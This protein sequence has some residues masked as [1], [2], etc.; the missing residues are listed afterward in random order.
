MTHESKQDKKQTLITNKMILQNCQQLK[1]S[2]SPSMS[3][4]IWTAYCT[5]QK[6]LIQDYCGVIS[7]HKSSSSS[8]NAKN[9]HVR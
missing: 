3:R 1:A 7:K 8:V 9:I 4:I 6:S 5:K 2:F